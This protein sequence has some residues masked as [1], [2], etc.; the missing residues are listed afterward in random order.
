MSPERR[1]QLRPSAREVFCPRCHAHPDEP[2]RSTRSPYGLCGPH[3][4]RLIEAEAYL[5]KKA[6]AA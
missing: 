3:T 6:A 2:C 1:A 5:A 4:E